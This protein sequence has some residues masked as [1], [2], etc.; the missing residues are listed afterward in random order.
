MADGISVGSLY[1]DLD[2]NDNNLK[3]HLDQADKDVQNF[4][5][6]ISESGEK[7]KAGL[8]K[9]AV[10]FAVVGA[11]L[12]LIDKQATDFTVNLV[13]SSKDLGREIG[14][15]TEEASR[16]TAA[17]NRMGIEADSARQMFGIF[18]KNIVAST[19]ST[20]SNRI[21]TEKLQLQVEA[22]KKSISDTTAEIAKHGD[23]NGNLTF[24]LRE[25]NN[26]L[27][28]ENDALAQSTDGF[29]KLGIKTVDATGKQKSFDTILFEVAD[30]FKTMPDGID[31]TTTAMQ[32]FGRQGKD[33]VKV[34]NLGGDGIK[35]LEKKAD[36]LGLTLNANTITKI[37]DL[38]QAQ[39][40][41]KEHT[42]SLKISIGT[43]TA[44]LLT[45]FNSALVDV[46]N[47]LL[48]TD[49]PLRGITAGFLAFAPPVFAAASGVFALAANLVTAWPAITAVTTA[50]GGFAVA[51]APVVA[52]LALIAAGLTAV[53]LGLNAI[54][55]AFDAVYNAQAAVDN[56]A[57]AGQIA[58]LQKEATAARAAGNTARAAQLGRT[59]N[60]LAGNAGGTD[61]WSGGLTWVHEQGPEI[62]DLPQG[63]RIIPHDLSKDM[64]RDGRATGA[65]K[66][67]TV[68]IGT[69]Q[70]RSDADYILR[71][72]DR[73]QQ[74]LNM[75]MSPA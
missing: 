64:M 72:L 18:S 62:I 1:Y 68:N 15:S 33:M 21:A 57:P 58:Q 46:T 35:D 11:G 39:K 36:Q 47:S 53:Y 54:K 19:G 3:G 40:D 22:T 25:L 5:N 43:A 24:K 42:D 23:K 50:M 30:K 41:L 12:G 75:G 60:A 7:L 28:A 45:E 61:N 9:A 6:N 48:A 65:N 49:S 14:V 66:N 74:R 10:G 63:T 52:V 31:K 2:V 13:K 38:I 26:T 56:L 16:L 29:A 59:I 73:S 55:G 67:V 51:A 27:K 17:F 37:N 71:R 32:L 70:D 44:P 20:D 69:V 34:L 4:G 8:N